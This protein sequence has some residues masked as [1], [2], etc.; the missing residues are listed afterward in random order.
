M[1]Q[2][3]RGGLCVCVEGSAFRNLVGDQ[4]ITPCQAGK[5]FALFQ[6]ETSEVQLPL[7][8]LTY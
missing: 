6:R 1:G 7:F 3:G 2:T 5:S 4:L 8:S